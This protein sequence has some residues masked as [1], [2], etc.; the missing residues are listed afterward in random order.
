MSNDTWVERQ[1]ATP[2][3]R[4][5]YEQER[6]IAWTFERIAHAMEY[7]DKSKADLAKS[8]G[9]SRA[10]ITQLLSGARNA[11]LR[12]IADLAWA[13]NS[14]VVI[15]VEPLR[16]GAFVSTPVCAVK[17]FRPNTSIKI[18]NTAE[19]ANEPRLS[20]SVVELAG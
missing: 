11:T 1:T 3:D 20:S 19:T 16:E 8:L 2:E 4:R 9:T 10:H 15:N 12:T 17:T 7:S 5:E 14:R 13:C 18:I 6:L